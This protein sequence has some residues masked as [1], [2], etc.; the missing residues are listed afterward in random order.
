MC[1]YRTIANEILNLIIGLQN[2]PKV[3]KKEEDCQSSDKWC[4]I[5]NNKIS[6]ECGSPVC[7][8]SHNR[9]DAKFAKSFQAR[10]NL[11]SKFGEFISP[12]L[13]PMF[14]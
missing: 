11:T 13:Y 7:A 8:L 14:S 6:T 12:A 9:V 4:M 1:D 3:T 5:S 10:Q 2:A